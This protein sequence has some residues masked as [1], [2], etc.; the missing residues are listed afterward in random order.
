MR[1]RGLILAVSAVA[2]IAGY[3]LFF[4]NPTAKPCATEITKEQARKIFADDMYKF[5][6]VYN[7]ANSTVKCS[8]GWG[9]GKRNASC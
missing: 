4:S 3:V 7:H 5:P 1:K 2:V 9:S 8:G 6:A